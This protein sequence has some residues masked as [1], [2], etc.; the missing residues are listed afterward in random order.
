MR[1]ILRLIREEWAAAAASL[2]QDEDEEKDEDGDEPSSKKVALHSSKL[3]RSN[4]GGLSAYASP[5][6]RS[7]AVPGADSQYSLS[8]FVLHG[9]PH[10][11]ANIFSSIFASSGRTDPATKPSKSAES[12]RPALVSAIEEVLDD[13]DTV[14]ETVSSTAKDHIHSE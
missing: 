8:N 12:I 5:A 1:R 11:D 6:I 4:T 2:P 9:R 10:R 3:P 7:H 13:L 14:F